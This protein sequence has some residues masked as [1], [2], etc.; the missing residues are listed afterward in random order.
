[1][2]KHVLWVV[3][4]DPCSFMLSLTSSTPG[5]PV[6]SVALK[7]TNSPTQGLVPRLT[8]IINENASVPSFTLVTA[9]ET[10]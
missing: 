1:M 3:L 9:L 4:N 6:E 2:R 7:S 10:P 8:S 5:V